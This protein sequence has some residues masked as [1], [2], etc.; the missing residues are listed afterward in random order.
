MIYVHI[1]GRTA[2]GGY[3]LEGF[4]APGRYYAAPGTPLK[5]DGEAPTGMVYAVD[6][7]RLTPVEPAA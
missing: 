4:D 2:D 1:V 5:P 7:A 3:E 6:R